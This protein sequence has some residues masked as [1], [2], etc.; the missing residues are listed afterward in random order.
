MPPILI[1]A[2]VGAVLA[3]LSKDKKDLPKAQQEDLEK[4]QIELAAA[5]KSVRHAQAKKDKF[6]AATGA[7]PIKV[8]K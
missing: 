6:I 2:L 7:K 4:L 3:L 1:L 5:R 8:D